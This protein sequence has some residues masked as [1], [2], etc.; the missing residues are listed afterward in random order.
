MNECFIILLVAIAILG[1]I[2]GMSFHTLTD[3]TLSP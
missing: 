3:E 2:L 1:I